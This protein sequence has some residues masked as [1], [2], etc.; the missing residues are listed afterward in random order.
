[1]GA[2]V[3]PDEYGDLL[4]RI[5]AEVRTT[6]CGSPARQARRSWRIGHLILARQEAEPWGAG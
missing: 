2:Q 3:V 5:T 1:M 4:A 6:R